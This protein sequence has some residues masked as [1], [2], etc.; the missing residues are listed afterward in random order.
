MKRM[1][2]GALMLTLL[3]GALTADVAMTD[4]SRKIALSGR[5]SLSRELS[6]CAEAFATL[7]GVQ[8]KSPL[9]TQFL[10]E[11]ANLREIYST[12]AVVYLA[13][14]L[15]NTRHIVS[16]FADGAVEKV[17]RVRGSNIIEVCDSATNTLERIRVEDRTRSS[18]LFW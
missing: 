4:S 18:A 11:G 12:E 15:N 9:A 3:M 16:Y 7:R 13:Y 17:S 2:S 6:Q 8:D 5:Y 14:E 1:I 10:P